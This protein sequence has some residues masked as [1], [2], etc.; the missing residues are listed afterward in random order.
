MCKVAFCVRTRQVVDVPDISVFSTVKVLFSVQEVVESVVSAAAT[1][2][3][4][5]KPLFAVRPRATLERH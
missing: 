2:G 4:E 1:A 5:R 3:Q